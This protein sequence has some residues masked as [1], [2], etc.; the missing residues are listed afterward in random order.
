MD[1]FYVK[2]KH[3][4]KWDYSIWKGFQYDY[5]SDEM[6]TNAL[7]Y[8][9]LDNIDLNIDW[10]DD[11]LLQ[12]DNSISDEFKHAIRIAGLVKKIQSNGIEIIQPIIIDTFTVETCCSCIYNGHHRIKALQY[13]KYDR[14][15][16]SLNG[17]NSELKKLRPTKKSS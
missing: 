6:I 7:N 12:N 13:L 17:Y 14:F 2:F 11:Y 8:S 1:V 5:I 4:E 9:N 3:I 10:E 16:A 15:P